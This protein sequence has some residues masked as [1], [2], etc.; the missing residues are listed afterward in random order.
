MN[1]L[2]KKEFER[3]AAKLNLSEHDAL[4]AYAAWCKAEAV[5]LGKSTQEAALLSSSAVST[6]KIYE[7][8]RNSLNKFKLMKENTM[9]EFA[10]NQLTK[11]EIQFLVMILRDQLNSAA[12]ARGGMKQY[13]GDLWNQCD[14][15]NPSTYY[16]FEK[17]NCMKT[18][19]RVFEKQY[20]KLQG[21]QNKLKKMR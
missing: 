16:E 17:M 1:S 12:E 8:I 13:I 3:F 20:K 7:V 14:P 6:S 5:C 11:Q 15:D 10:E 4:I 9:Q 19:L 18:D 21:I 2:H